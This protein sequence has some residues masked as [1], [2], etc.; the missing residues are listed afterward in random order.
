M[1]TKNRAISFWLIGAICI[2]LA[3]VSATGAHG[4]ST[5]FA[6]TISFML[7]LVGG[8]F[9]ISIMHMDEEK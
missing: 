1:A 6:Y 4:D 8:M 7:T 2:F 5:M 9:W 3:M